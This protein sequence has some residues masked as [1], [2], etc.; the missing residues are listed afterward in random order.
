M[1]VVDNLTA[2]GGKQRATLTWNYHYTESGEGDIDYT[3]LGRFLL[4]TSFFPDMNPVYSASWVYDLSYVDSLPPGSTKYYRIQPRTTTER[5]WD[6]SPIV[7]AT[8]ISTDP[9]WSAPWV[10]LEGELSA[11]VGSASCQVPGFAPSGNMLH[12]RVG[13]V[14]SIAGNFTIVSLAGASGWLQFGPVPYPMRTSPRVAA[15]GGVV[16]G[17]PSNYMVNAQIVPKPGSPDE[18]VV[19][20]YNNDGSFAGVVGYSYFVNG[21]FELRDDWE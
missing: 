15:R 9:T 7:S 4:Q 21:D 6:W 10:R 20:L 8:E 18:T 12:H 3:R 14:I 2:V 13:R 19:R 16:S 11:E 17:L 5:E 1:I